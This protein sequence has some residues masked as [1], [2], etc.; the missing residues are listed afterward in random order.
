MITHLAELLPEFPG[1]ANHTCCFA[2]ILNLVAKCIMYQFDAPKKSKTKSFN[3]EENLTNTHDLETD[4][5]ESDGEDEEKE[6]DLQLEEIAGEDEDDMADEDG[7]DVMTMAEIKQLEENVKP[8]RQVL[9]K[10]MSHTID[11]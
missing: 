1:Q 8:M 5:L 11:K 3:N 7:H 2:H 9:T 10:V 6:E 4:D